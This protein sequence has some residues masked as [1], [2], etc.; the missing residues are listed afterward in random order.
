MLRVSVIVPTRDRP[1][2]LAQALASVRA[3]ESRG[4]ELELVVAGDG[5][6]LESRSVAERFGAVWVESRKHGAAAARN[7]GLGAATGRF[8]AF[9]D[10]DEFP[11]AGWL[12]NLFRVCQKGDCSESYQRQTTFPT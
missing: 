12:L 11:A 9:L 3:N 5:A 8:I 6:S 4:F 7:A 2:L 10:D 1:E